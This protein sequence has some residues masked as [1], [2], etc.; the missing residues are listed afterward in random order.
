MRNRSANKVAKILFLLADL[1]LKLAKS[2]LGNFSKTFLLADIFAHH[3]FYSQCQFAPLHFIEMWAEI[4][5]CVMTRMHSKKKIHFQT[6]EKGTVIRLRQ[7]Q[8]RIIV[9]SVSAEIDGSCCCGIFTIDC[10]C[11]FITSMLSN[12]LQFCRNALS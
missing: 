8:T 12:G 10:C 9:W 6:R 2:G 7:I 3:C 11:Y 1:H 5:S 4:F